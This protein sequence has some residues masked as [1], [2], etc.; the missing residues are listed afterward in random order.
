MMVTR[1]LRGLSGPV[2]PHLADGLPQPGASTYP[3]VVLRPGVVGSPLRFP[4]QTLKKR[5]EAIDESSPS[6]LVICAGA[7]PSLL[8]YLLSIVPDP[9]AHFALAHSRSR[10]VQA[11]S[12]PP[13]SHNFNFRWTAI[14]FLACRDKH[15]D[16]PP[17]T[18]IQFTMHNCPRTTD[19]SSTSPPAPSSALARVVTCP[20]LRKSHTLPCC[21]P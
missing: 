7:T 13:E 3:I 8:H 6:V 21:L 12:S 16:I 14:S 17:L 4:K 15:D 18:P 10:E 1:I 20:S 2:K 9:T 11:P 19:C 5:Q